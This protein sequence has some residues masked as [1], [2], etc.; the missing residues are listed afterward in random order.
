MHRVK[1]RPAARLRRDHLAA[2]NEGFRFQL[3]GGSDDRPVTFQPAYPHAG[4][5][6]R[7]GPIENELGATAIIFDFAQPAVANRRLQRQD[8]L[9]RLDELQTH[10]LTRKLR[11]NLA[12]A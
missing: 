7:A 1:V 4:E 5:G 10:E 12:H 9:L 6:E 3:L 11:F 8:R 2:G